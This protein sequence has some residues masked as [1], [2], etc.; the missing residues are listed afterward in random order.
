MSMGRVRLKLPSWIA[1]ML[2]EKASDWLT[3]E[4][5]IEE[6]ATIS[7]LLTS[8]VATYPGFRQAVFNPDT[9][10]LN[11]QINVVLNDKLLTF[12]EVTQTKLR[13]GDTIV[14]VPIYYGG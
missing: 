9:G 13:D 2:D 1:T 6:D 12:Q 3:L 14:L 7:D 10:H 11:D 8:L 4:K 5:E